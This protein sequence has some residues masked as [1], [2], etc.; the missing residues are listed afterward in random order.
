MC[1]YTRRQVKINTKQDPHALKCTKV[2]PNALIFYQILS[3]YSS[4]KWMQNSQEKFYVD[5]NCQA[6]RVKAG[7]AGSEVWNRVYMFAPVKKFGRVRLSTN[8]PW[9]QIW[10]RMRTWKDDEVLLS[11]KFSRVQISRKGFYELFYWSFWTWRDAWTVHGWLHLT[12]FGI[13]ASSV[14]FKLR[15]FSS[16]H[17][18]LF[19]I[20]FHLQW[21]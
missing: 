10:R 5:I 20:F 6:W 9:K 21:Y 11:F 18:A 2:A 3:T 12:W 19:L 14:I 16:D 1:W 7:G 17:L 4:R 15:E 8:F 13:S